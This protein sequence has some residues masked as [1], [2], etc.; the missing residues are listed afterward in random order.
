MRVSNEHMK[1]LDFWV[2]KSRI[3]S[4]VFW[5]KKKNL[6]NPE[7][8]DYPKKN[9]NTE[10]CEKILCGYRIIDI[11]GCWIKISYSLFVETNKTIL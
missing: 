9:R 2:G 4:K 6:A 3:D 7:N 10:K 11:L 8:P 5:D 1:N